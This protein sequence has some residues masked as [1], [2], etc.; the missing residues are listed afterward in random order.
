MLTP[1]DRLVLSS[2]LC[3]FFATLHHPSIAIQN[4]TS[5]IENLPAPVRKQREPLWRVCS[6]RCWIPNEAAWRATCFANIISTS[7]PIRLVLNAPAFVLDTLSPFADHKSLA[8]LAVSNALHHPLPCNFDL[9]IEPW[10]DLGVPGVAGSIADGSCTCG[11]DSLAAK[12]EFRTELR[13]R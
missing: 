10:A 9:A 11:L 13:K 12:A 8:A 5:S 4:T 7:A 2:I 1:Q 3:A 6:N